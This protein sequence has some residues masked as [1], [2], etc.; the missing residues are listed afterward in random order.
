[1]TDE[2]LK[3]LYD[4]IFNTKESEKKKLAMLNVSRFGYYTDYL[5]RL[6]W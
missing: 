2:Q 1:M 5:V 4:E 3:Q 6:L